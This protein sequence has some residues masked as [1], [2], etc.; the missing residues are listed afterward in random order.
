M[1]L[2]EQEKRSTLRRPLVALNDK[3]RAILAAMVYGLEGKMAEK[4]G[5]EPGK[6][7]GVNQVADV[8]RLRR[9]YVRSLLLDPLFSAELARA[10]N[11][12]QQAHTP[13]ALDRTISLMRSEDERVA[14]KACQDIR[15]AGRQGLNVSVGVA[16]APH[17]GI[18]PG[19]VIKLPPELEPAPAIENETPP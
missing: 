6:G 4:N 3:G 18:R 8:F 17:V 1:S 16:V 7:L 9:R 14:L 11:A 2:T 13:E 5:V 10:V 19:Y 12:K 15:G